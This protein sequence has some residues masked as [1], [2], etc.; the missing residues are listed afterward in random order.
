MMAVGICIMV[1]AV[2]VAKQKEGA[3]KSRNLSRWYFAVVIVLMLVG[4]E[5]KK[6]IMEGACDEE[7]SNRRK[8]LEAYRGGILLLPLYYW[9]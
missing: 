1:F 8:K 3:R 2:F 6:M 9:L 5:L 4:V 7:K